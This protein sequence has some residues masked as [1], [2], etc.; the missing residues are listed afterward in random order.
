MKRLI[1][2]LLVVLLVGC[3]SLYTTTVTITKVRDSAMKELAA[4]NKQGKITPDTDA[5]IA[6][7]DL[8]YRRAAEVAEK[9]LI[10]YKAGGEA[11]QYTA[12]LQAVKVALSGVLD[13]LGQFITSSE[14]AGYTKQLVKAN[15][16]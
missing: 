6:Q 5:K 11:T 12:A 9:A 13:I 1:A 7:A 16:L 4:L 15:A 10:A 8:A 3:T 2:S 14:K